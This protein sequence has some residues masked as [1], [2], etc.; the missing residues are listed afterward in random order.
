MRA[1]ITK[2]FLAVS[3]ISFASTGVFA[4]EEEKVLN[5][6]NWSDYIAED[7][8]T[9]F[10]AETGIKVN[11]DVYDANEKLEAKLLA[12]NSGY[13][14]VFPS[15][16]PFLALQ[17]KAGIYQKLDKTKLANYG[18]IEESA[19]KALAAS[20]PGNLFAV[21]YM[22]APT[23]IGYNVDK[24][25]ALLPDAPLGSWAMVLD[26]KVVSKL[27]ACGVT[28]LDAPDEVY[29]AALA[30]LGKDPISSAKDDLKTAQDH[31]MKVRGHLKYIHSSQYI[32]DLANGDICVAHGY[33]GDLIQARDRA[34]EAGKG[35]NIEVVVPKEGAVVV[36]DVMAIPADAPHPGNAHKF[37]DF[38][39]R[40][41]V[42]GAITNAV[43][44]SNSIKGAEQHVDAAILN[45]PAIY[46]PAEVRAKFFVV[47][48]FEQAYLRD[49]TRAWTK[50]KSRQ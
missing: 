10:E 34:A 2:A 18:K 43:G 38:M 39:M 19:L 45:D 50:F 22:T 48:P 15:A 30:F 31:I 11:Y 27:A 41:D 40:P 16:S 36:T 1:S 8:L 13:D 49:R 25:K 23:G 6:Y 33:G 21:P 28:L 14:V 4:A 5:V 24:I 44:Y 17:A 32:N 35:V 3:A 42:V 9:R 46:P 47:P 7:T 20:D 26:A 37:I 12:G 29:P